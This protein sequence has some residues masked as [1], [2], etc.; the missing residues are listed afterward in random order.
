MSGL[1]ELTRRRRFICDLF[2]SD[3]YNLCVDG[4]P[5]FLLAS[6]AKATSRLRSEIEENTE[7]KLKVVFISAGFH[8]LLPAKTCMTVALWLV[9]YFLS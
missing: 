6:G 7:T 8:G 5:S 3:I 1:P 4:R 2:S 9:L